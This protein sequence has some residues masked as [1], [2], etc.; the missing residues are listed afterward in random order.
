[1]NAHAGDLRVVEDDAVDQV[2]ERIL[3]LIQQTSAVAEQNI[4]NARNAADGFAFQLRAAED[5]IRT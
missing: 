4:R 3:G 5:R 1:M 2:G